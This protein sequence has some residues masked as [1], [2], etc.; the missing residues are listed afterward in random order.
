M[1]EPTDVVL[2]CRSVVRRFRE[3]DST[4]EVLSGVDLV[5]RSAERLAI[6]GA[7]G[8]GKTTLLQIMGG[9]DEPSGGNVLV[10]GQTIASID[11]A[12]KEALL[13]STHL[14]RAITVRTCA[15]LSTWLGA[16]TIA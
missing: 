10:N 2:E 6:I 5:V 8:S 4:L 3:G 13:D 12:A 16:R 14:P 9:L 15:G 1:S 7:S 11:E